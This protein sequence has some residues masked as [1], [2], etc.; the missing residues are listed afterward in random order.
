[1]LLLLLVQLTTT[2]RLVVLLNL[3]AKDV[4]FHLFHTQRNNKGQLSLP[5]LLPSG[6]DK[7][8]TS[9]SGEVCSLVSGKRQHC[10]IPYGKWHPVALRWSF[11]VSLTAQLFINFTQLLESIVVRWPDCVFIAANSKAMSDSPVFYVSV[12]CAAIAAHFQ[13]Q[14]AYQCNA[15]MH[16]LY[17]MPILFAEMSTTPTCTCFTFKFWNL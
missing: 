7:S 14:M 1:L 12:W 11:T 5:S 4:V 8:I 15:C 6:I 17:C 3:L 10:V 16:T 9:L 13:A 2:D